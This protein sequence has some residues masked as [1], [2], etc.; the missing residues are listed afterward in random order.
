VDGDG[1]LS[2]DEATA[3]RAIL[4]GD[5]LGGGAYHYP[6]GLACKSDLLHQPPVPH[7]S[8]TRRGAAGRTYDPRRSWQ[9][10]QGSYGNGG[11]A[12]RAPHIGGRNGGRMTIEEEND[13][14]EQQ[15]HQQREGKLMP[16]GFI[17]ETPQFQQPQQQRLRPPMNRRPT[18]SQ[19]GRRNS[20]GYGYYNGGDH[21]RSGYYPPFAPS[22]MLPVINQQPAQSVPA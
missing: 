6:M 21:P 22:P 10:G 5:P 14:M 15:Q 18:S 9:G 17:E 7:A 1:I 12:W 13:L 8:R 16:G 11:M 19:S 3:R 2:R 4:Q 20:S